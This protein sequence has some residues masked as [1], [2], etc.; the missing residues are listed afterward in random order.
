MK[1]NLSVFLIYCFMQR[2]AFY[3]SSVV[4]LISSI[5][6]VVISIASLSSYGAAVGAISMVFALLG[7]S[8]TLTFIIILS[9]HIYGR[10]VS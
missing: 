4:G 2:H 8:F 3:G 1:S 9:Q 7:F 6:H 5:S 10:Y